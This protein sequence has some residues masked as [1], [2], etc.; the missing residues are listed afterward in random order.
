MA[1]TRV[2]VCVTV[3]RNCE[4]LIRVGAEL[5]GGTEG[6]LSVVH[7]ARTGQRFL[8]SE[9]EAA[10]LEYL[11]QVSREN[12]AD[13]TLLHSDDVGASIVAMAKKCGAEVIVL[14]APPQNTRGMQLPALLRAQLPGVDV[15]EII[16]T[17][18]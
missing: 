8:G 2:L 15:K 10:A 9:D 12:G 4:R 18:E 17:G 3:Q 16:T 14:G 7:V 6:S 5:A 13:M 1:K 11:F